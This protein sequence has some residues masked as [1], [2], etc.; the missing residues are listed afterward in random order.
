MLLDLELSC[1]KI[2]KILEEPSTWECLGG[3]ETAVVLSES[4][5][6]GDV[7]GCSGSEVGMRGIFENTRDDE[8]SLDL[9]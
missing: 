2:S 5:R 4:C 1:Y 7:A 6:T 9:S 3:D 8:I